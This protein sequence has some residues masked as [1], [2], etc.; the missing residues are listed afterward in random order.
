MKPAVTIILLLAIIAS[1]MVLTL[2]AVKK[3][4]DTRNR[5]STALIAPM[6]ISTT[7]TAVKVGDE[8]LVDVTLDASSMVVYAADVVVTFD[9]GT[10]SGVSFV[11]GGFFPANFTLLPGQI[12]AG[13]ARIALSNQPGGLISGKG[14]LATLK[15]KALHYS[16]SSPVV[17]SALTRV[18][19]TNS[20]LAA[21]TPQ[22]LQIQ[23]CND[24]NRNNKC[25]K[26]K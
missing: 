8:V 15:L 19:T 6:T 25:T 20:A 21:A 12:A 14:T 22:T 10:F 18:S 7:K 26:G 11:N 13:T 16:K 1:G 4:Q 17:L 5:T 24:F 2:S 23:V 9:P 3:N